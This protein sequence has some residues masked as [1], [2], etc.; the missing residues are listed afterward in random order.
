MIFKAKQ[1]KANFCMRLAY[2][3]TRLIKIFVILCLR[4]EYAL[5][6]KT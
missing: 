3:L 1:M 4:K 2:L 5:L 6:M